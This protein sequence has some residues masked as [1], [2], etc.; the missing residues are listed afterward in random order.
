MSAVRQYSTF[1]VDRF[2]FGVEVDRVQ[3]ALLPMRTTPV[4]LT[5]PVVDGLINLRGQIV[6]AIDLRAR[7]NM[8]RP[9]P[10]TPSVSLILR[11]VNGL[12]SLRVDQLG[13]VLDLEAM[14]MDSAND[15][16]VDAGLS[17][18]HRS[19]IGRPRMWEAVP[20]T[21]C[22]PLRDLVR[23]ILKLEH[24]LLLILDPDLLA[25]PSVCLAVEERPGRG[26]E[27]QAARQVQPGR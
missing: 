3:E 25:D 13:D 2:H 12:V 1:F 26:E 10:H 24:S 8:P 6:T 5:T 23:G 27:L 21:V 15:E 14:A 4:P 16:G 9:E 19:D 22:G 20:E 7:L 17:P 11:T 18:D